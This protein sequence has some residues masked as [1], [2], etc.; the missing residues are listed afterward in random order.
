M[1]D[2]AIGKIEV[3]HESRQLLHFTAL[4]DVA[5]HVSTQR[6]FADKEK[7]LETDLCV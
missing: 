5:L 2:F 4:R 3:K 6:H 1:H 7:M